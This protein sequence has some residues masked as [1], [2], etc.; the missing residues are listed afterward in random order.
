MKKLIG[1]ALFGLILAAGCGPEPA[2]QESSPAPAPSQQQS[3]QPAENQPTGDAQP[4]AIE[5]DDTAVLPAGWKTYQALKYG[6]KISFPPTWASAKE[7]FGFSEHMYP[8][9]GYV[10][11]HPDGTRFTIFQIQILTKEQWAKWE[12]KGKM[13]VLAENDTHIFLFADD[14]DDMKDDC[15]GG[16]Q[17]DKDEQDRCK[18]TSQI[19]K[20]FSLIE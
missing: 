16:G 13:H 8:D 5:S 2:H 19:V 3:A 10:G 9:F 17:F 20:T 6:F 14:P 4:E 12:S 11:F 18:E 7:D 15:T 1:V